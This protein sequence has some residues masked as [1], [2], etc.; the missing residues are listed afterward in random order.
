MIIDGHAHCGGAFFKPDTLLSRL[1]ELGVDKV[2]LCQNIRQ[3]PRDIRL[4]FENRE[5]GRNGKVSFVGNRLLRLGARLA[6]AKRG[7]TERNA[8]VLSLAEKRPDRIVP[9]FWADPSHPAVLEDLD[10]AVRIDG[11]RGLKLHQCVNRFSC[12]D[13]V[14]DAIAACAAANG[15]P[16]FI[17][18]YSGGEVVRFMAWAGR[19][20]RTRFIVAHL[21][22]MEIMAV[23]ASS[24]KNVTL[25]ISPAWGSTKARL[26][27]AAAAFGVDRLVL[28]SDTPFGRDTLEKNIRKV[29]NLDFSARDQ[30]L[31]LGL[32]MARLLNLPLRGGFQEP[33][34]AI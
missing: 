12:A 4:P 19:N 31:I 28:G 21:I 23:R 15:I 6:R 10:R 17:H 24:L 34:G 9:F 20:P 1:D 3:S 7:R 2:V 11:F 33:A 18:L 22:G 30:A 8:Y 29:R 5:I 26:R 25:D 13:P 32:N 27:R 14:M 16:V